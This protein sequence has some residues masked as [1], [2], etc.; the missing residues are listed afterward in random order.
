[1]LCVIFRSHTFYVSAFILRYAKKPAVFT[2]EGFCNNE[3]S[4]HIYIKFT[5]DRDPYAN[6]QQ[7]VPYASKPLY[8]ATRI[9]LN[10][11]VGA[12]SAAPTTF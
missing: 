8:G 10:V 5:D 1:M 4:C 2:T 12:C 6:K 7:N 3:Q 9:R 11:E